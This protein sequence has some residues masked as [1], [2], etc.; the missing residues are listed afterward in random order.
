MEEIHFGEA[1]TSL[2]LI[3]VFT[4]ARHW[5]KR[6]ASWI[7]STPSSDISLSSIKTVPFIYAWVFKLLLYCNFHNQNSVGISIHLM[8]APF[9]SPLFLLYCITP[10]LF[11][12]N[13]KPWSENGLT[14]ELLFSGHAGDL[15]WSAGDGSSVVL[16]GFSSEVH[17]QDGPLRASRG[18]RRLVLVSSLVWTW[19][20]RTVQKTVSHYV[21]LTDQI[22]ENRFQKLRYMFLKLRSRVQKFPAWP[23]F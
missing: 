3:T 4:V 7:H 1:E 11:C 12:E 2:N 5:F 21:C 10:I 17:R 23:T 14:V 19:A 20:C 22:Y 8:L 15:L 13:C 16:Q 18:Q 9:T 6:G